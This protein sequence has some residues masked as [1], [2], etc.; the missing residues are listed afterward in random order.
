M[1]VYEREVAP[2][3]DI[4]QIVGTDGSCRLSRIAENPEVKAM[5][6]LL[7]KDTVDG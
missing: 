4:I 7:R 1:V 2:Q 6:V 3:N 5:K